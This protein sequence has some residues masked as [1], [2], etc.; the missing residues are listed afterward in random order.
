MFWYCGNGFLSHKQTPPGCPIQYC[1]GG[2]RCERATA[3]L[4]EISEADPSFNT[5]GVYELRGGIHRYLKSYPEGGHWVG[6]NYVFD[7]RRVQVPDRKAHNETLSRC[8]A[9]ECQWDTYRGKFKCA[10]CGCP[11]LVCDQCR[12]GIEEGA[13]G[14]HDPLSL[15]CDLC[16]VGYTAPTKRPKLKRK[17]REGDAVA[18]AS[19]AQKRQRCK[20][21]DAATPTSMMSRLYVAKLP[22][23]VTFSDVRSALSD[24]VGCK[25]A[26]IEYAEWKLDRKTK[27]FYG[28]SFVKVAD[29]SLARQLIAAGG[30][31]EGIRV[32]GRRIKIAM[33]PLQTHETMDW[34]GSKA[35]QLQRPPLPP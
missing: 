32:R 22:F 23:M 3:L 6:K 18:T 33:A 4:N 13:P 30:E 19:A 10:S 9:C 11:V 8:A 25:V 17:R 27:L 29:M 5:N 21:D 14:A 20:P 35:V 16:R 24:A 2:I 31:G 7:K 1:T 12:F 28:T 34:P 15:R 26:Q